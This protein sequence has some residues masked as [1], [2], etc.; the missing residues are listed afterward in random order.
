M[1]NEVLMKEKLFLV[2][3]SWKKMVKIFGDIKV[4]GEVLFWKLVL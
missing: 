3:L 2:V 1:G 4:L